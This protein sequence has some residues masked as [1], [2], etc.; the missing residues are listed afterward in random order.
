MAGN[1]CFTKISKALV[2]GAYNITGGCGNTIAAIFSTSLLTSKKS[3]DWEQ[4][5]TE[6]VCLLLR[7]G[8]L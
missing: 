2:S 8:P 4:Y 6:P 7:G 5:K 3:T 1:C